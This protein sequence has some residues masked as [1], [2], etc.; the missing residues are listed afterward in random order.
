MTVCALSAQKL[1]CLSQRRNPHDPILI[2]TEVINEAKNVLQSKH[3][4]SNL[5]K[6]EEMVKKVCNKFRAKPV[7][8]TADDRRKG[9]AHFLRMRRR[10]QEERIEE[11]DCVILAGMKRHKVTAVMSGDYKFIQEAKRMG[12]NILSLS[13]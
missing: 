4:I 7:K 1:D 5:S 11:I 13:T 12:F 6:A 3:G 2:L 8:T 10:P 9:K